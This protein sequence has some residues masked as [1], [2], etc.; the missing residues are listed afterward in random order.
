MSDFYEDISSDE[1]E[2]HYHETAQPLVTDSSQDL[3][4][5]SVNS[6]D[7]PEIND[8]FVSEIL[9]DIEEEETCARPTEESLESPDVSE[10]ANSSSEDS[11]MYD[12]DDNNNR[13]SV[14]TSTICLVMKKTIRT[15]PDGSEEI[16][17]ESQIIYSENVNPE[18]VDFRD[19]AEEIL[20]EVPRHLA[21]SASSNG[22]FVLVIHVT[23]WRPY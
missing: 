9:G 19:L 6:E 14:E 2:M 17:R 16:N 13:V 21:P 22:R 15:N 11:D 18:E 4:I 3:D 12:M 20:N 23:N 7:L 8:T 1:E 10:A 5:I